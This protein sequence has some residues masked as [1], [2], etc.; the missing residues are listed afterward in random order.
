MEDK[1]LVEQLMQA[2]GLLHRHQHLDAMRRGCPGHI[3]R[4]QGRVLSLLKLQPE[5][6]QKELSYL[7]DMRSQSLGELL[8]K[9]EKNGYITRAPSEQDR[10]VMEI[11]LT[12]AGKEAADET[13]KQQEDFG[14]VLDFL[15][16]EEKHQL[17][18]VLEH[19]IAELEPKLKEADISG[20]GF[21]FERPPFPGGM[22]HECGSGGC[23]RHRPPSAGEQGGCHHGHDG[24]ET[25][26]GRCHSGGAARG[27]CHGHQQKGPQGPWQER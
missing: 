6:S 12:D 11:K 23:Q 26:H 13:E 7:L 18:S 27:K 4:G 2:Y 10:R 8:A 19:I 21:G 22:P 24:G 16:D 3:H 1:T 25:R 17:S 15:S 5:I 20:F 14:K 9:L